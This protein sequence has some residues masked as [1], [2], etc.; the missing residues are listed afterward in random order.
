MTEQKNKKTFF[1][2]RVEECMHSL[3]VMANRLTR[4]S[5]DAE[6]LMAD[7]VTKAWSASFMVTAEL[8]MWEPIHSI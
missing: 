8:V 5:A 3:Y 6:D 2:H 4:N 1:S 7:A